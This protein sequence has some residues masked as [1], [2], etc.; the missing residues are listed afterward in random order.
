MQHVQGKLTIT[1]HMSKKFKTPHAQTHAQSIQTL[2]GH[3]AAERS[4]TAMLHLITV[5]V[6]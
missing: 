6:F 2:V 5:I 4:S 3:P 1:F